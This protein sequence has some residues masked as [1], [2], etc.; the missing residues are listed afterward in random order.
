M[1]TIEKNVRKSGLYPWGEG[2]TYKNSTVFIDRVAQL[3]KEG[4]TEKEALAILN[5]TLPENYR[6]GLTAFR[7]ARN[8][9]CYDRN[10][11]ICEKI[12]E[13]RDSGASWMDIAHKFGISERSAE[14][15]YAKESERFHK[16][17][18]IENVAKALLNELDDKKMIYISKRDQKLEV[19]EAL[20]DTA[21]YWLISKGLALRYGI[22]KKGEN[23]CLTVVAKPEYPRDYA[24]A[25][26]DEI[27]EL[28]SHRL[29]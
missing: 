23:R 17:T 8:K 14:Y 7:Y 15:K 6:M 4:K 19:S 10:I 22:K 13:M 12:H 29:A 24:L 2:S 25:H 1:S 20:V 26:L 28:D 11:E 9:A 3:S 5:E 27:K 18:A 21:I 16:F